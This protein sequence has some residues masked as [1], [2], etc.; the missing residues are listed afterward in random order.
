MGERRSERGDRLFTVYN[1]EKNK[2][3]WEIKKDKK[4]IK[5]LS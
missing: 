2:Y 3:W 4:E 5:E 1:F